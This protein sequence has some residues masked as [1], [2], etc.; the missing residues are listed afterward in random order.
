MSGVFMFGASAVE[1]NAS[2]CALATASD[3][4]SA[5]KKSVRT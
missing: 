3:L 5:Q 4:E 2:I 1:V